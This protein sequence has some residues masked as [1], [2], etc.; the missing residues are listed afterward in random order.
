MDGVMAE[1]LKT[2]TEFTTKIVKRLLDEIWESEILPK[3]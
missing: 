3:D 1:I 2:Y